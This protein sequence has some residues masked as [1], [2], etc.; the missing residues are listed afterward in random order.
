MFIDREFLIWNDAI[1]FDILSDF[2][3]VEFL[4]VSFMS[5]KNNSLVYLEIWGIKFTP[6]LS[7]SL[8]LFLPPSSFLQI[9]IKPITEMQLLH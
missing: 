7:L 9:F 2:F 5:F 4:Y 8:F 1:P 6:F 3:P